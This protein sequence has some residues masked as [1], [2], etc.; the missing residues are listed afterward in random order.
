MAFKNIAQPETTEERIA[1]AKKMKD[2]YEL[3]MPILVDTMEDQSRALLSDLPS[4]VFVVDAKGIIRVKLPW[5]DFGLIRRA[6]LQ[7][8]AGN[9]QLPSTLVQGPVFGLA[10]PVGESI[11]NHGVNHQLQGVVSHD[12]QDA[13]L[14]ANC[15]RQSN[16]QSLLATS[17]S[18][19]DLL[20][21]GKSD[22]TCGQLA[23]KENRDMNEQ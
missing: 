2:E 5:P 8:S 19:G 6:V 21:V 13:D 16:H 3:P 9:Q 14:Q 7:T 20:N 10:N 17:E 12:R 4:P 18:D 22:G 23:R 15:D 1:L 11:S